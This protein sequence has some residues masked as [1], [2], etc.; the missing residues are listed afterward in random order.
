M[1]VVIL[2]VASVLAYDIVRHKLYKKRRELLLI[3]AISAAA[4]ALGYLY[5][6]DPYRETIAGMFMKWMRK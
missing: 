1:I 4:L 2:A 5:A 3:L 6:A